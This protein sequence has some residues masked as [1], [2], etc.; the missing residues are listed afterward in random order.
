MSALIWREQKAIPTCL[1]SEKVFE[2]FNRFT[3]LGRLIFCVHLHGT[4]TASG[5]SLPG[6]V[7]KI[8]RPPLGTPACTMALSRPSPRH[9]KENGAGREK[10]NGKRAGEE[11]GREGK[12]KE[13]KVL[14]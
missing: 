11:K 12:E 8:L 2:D 10:R 1:L 3:G 4:N 14:T 13:R 7:G 9:R 6:W 5:S